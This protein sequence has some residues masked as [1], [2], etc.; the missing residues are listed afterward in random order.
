MIELQKNERASL[1]S[2]C[3]GKSDVELFSCIEGK[4]GQ[5][6]ANSKENPTLAVILVADFCFL[7]G[8]SEKLQ[9]GDYIKKLY[10]NIRRKIIVPD[11]QFWI[12]VIAKYFPNNHRKFSRYSIKTEP[13]VFNK[14][15]LN[16]YVRA[17]ESKFNIVNIDKTN[18]NKVLADD[19][20]A[21]CCSNYSSLEDFTENGLGYLIIYEDEII[22][23]A[24]SYGYC[25]G[26]IEITIGTKEEYRQKGLALACASKLILNCLDRGIYPRW[27]AANLESVALA[28]KLGYHFD[29]EYIV[30]SIF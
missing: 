23:A 9:D 5:V 18:Y 19:F 11:S 8:H 22:S 30:Y 6:W 26:S 15:K 17:I 24:S 1:Q 7:L 25:K 20:M 14:A 4:T 27:D 12:D 29:K 16:S 10:D 13:K 28:E 21:D 3:V 2:L